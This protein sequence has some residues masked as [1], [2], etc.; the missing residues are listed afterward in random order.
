MLIEE[1]ITQQGFSVAV[2]IYLLYERSKGMDK[3]IRALYAVEKALIKLE[4]KLHG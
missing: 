3:I 2:V 4:G 1:V